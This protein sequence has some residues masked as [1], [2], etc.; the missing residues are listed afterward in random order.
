MVEAARFV[1]IR[2]R[3]KATLDAQQGRELPEFVFEFAF[4]KKKIEALSERID[5]VKMVNHYFAL[6][7]TTYQ[8]ANHLYISLQKNYPSVRQLHLRATKETVDDLS[9][10]A[11]WFESSMKAFES[12][13]LSLK[14]LAKTGYKQT[15]QIAEISNFKN[16]GVELSDLYQEN[17][18]LWNYKVFA[19]SARQVIEKVIFPMREN[20]LAYDQEINK[21][22]EKM[23]RD[24]VSVRSELRKFI[25]KIVYD[26]FKQVDREPLPMIVLNLKVADVEYRSVL[27]EHAPFLDSADIAFQISM[28]DKEISLLQKIDSLAEKISAMNVD[29]KALDYDHFIKNA[30][31]NTA[32]LKSYL[33]TQREYGE[34][35]QKKKRATQTRLVNSL[36]YIVD[37]AD[38]IP[39][40][41]EMAR[42]H[43]T[44]FTSDEKFVVGLYFP[45]T[46]HV[47]G[48]FYTITASRKPEMKA[49]F[50]VNN[51]SCSPINLL[52]I[53]ALAY[54]DGAGQIYYV[55]I[56]SDKSVKEKFPATLAKI[57][58]SDGLAWSM[59]YQLTFAPSDLS[60]A[61]DT[62][63]LTIRNNFQN[64]VVD[65]SGKVIQ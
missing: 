63:E 9:N 54:S 30:Y 45:D 34:R 2:M 39:L 11:V 51:F 55:L 43:K 22:R 46:V 7:D 52:G 58:R 16:E 62:G 61:T 13:Q 4:A 18:K 42:P 64:L 19:D 10:L 32:V 29:E 31:S 5:Q 59:N 47:K 23:T 33:R 60:V 26:Q 35:E 3:H 56:Y 38:S 15:L 57:Y 65:K 40:S 36:R 41:L 17:P 12:Y 50:P 44:L 1:E 48:Y 20:F 6:A 8:R 25:D 49:L 14:S 28:V 53:K 27:L 37:G 21:L 24:S